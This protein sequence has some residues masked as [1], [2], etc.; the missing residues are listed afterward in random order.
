VFCIRDHCCIITCMIIV[1]EC[2]RLTVR[3]TIDS[4]LWEQIV[5]PDVFRK[6]IDKHADLVAVHEAL[7]S[8]RLTGYICDSIAT[9]EGLKLRDRPEFMTGQ[10][11]R[12]R[13]LGADPA[14]P[15]AVV[16]APNDLESVPQRRQRDGVVRHGRRLLSRNSVTSA[17]ARSPGMP[18]PRSR[19]S[20]PTRM[21]A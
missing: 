3:I 5:H 8:K 18:S 4:N 19:S 13:L 17:N 1:L 16:F 10:T 2:W 6:P 14:E 11:M 7:R 20:R 15:K 12:P 21:S 9:L